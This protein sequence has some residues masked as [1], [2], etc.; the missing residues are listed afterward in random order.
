MHYFHI[1]MTTDIF[2]H[3]S[4]RTLL[5]K[6]FLLLYMSQQLR[7]YFNGASLYWGIKGYYIRN[8]TW[9]TSTFCVNVFVISLFQNLFI[10]LIIFIQLVL[11]LLYEGWDNPSK[12]QIKPLLKNCY[13]TDF[14]Y[15]YWH[16]WMI[17]CCKIC[18]QK[19][20]MLGG[21][22]LQSICTGQSAVSYL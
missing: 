13:K 15:W 11:A 5:I 8:M 18:S 14:V 3:L 22:K 4:C 17:E 21:M 10:H 9:W 1:T 19:F 16:D 6:F 7:I 12:K 2:Q 20:W